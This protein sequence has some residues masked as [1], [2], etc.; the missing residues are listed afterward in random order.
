MKEPRVLHVNDC[1]FTTTVL[2]REARR[3]RLPWTYQPL[4]TADPTWHGLTGKLRYAARAAPWVVSLGA[5]AARTD[6]LHIHFATVVQH[7]G[8]VPRPYVL[9]LHGTDIRTYQ[10]DPRYAALVARAVERAAAVLYST[11]DLRV[12]AHRLRPDATHFPVPVNVVALPFWRPPAEPTVFFASRWEP[13]KGLPVQLAIARELT[14]RH[15]DDIRLVGVDWGV[16]SGAARELGVELRPRASHHEFLEHLAQTH[17]V[18]GQPTG[19]LSASELEA[20]GI[21]VPV[22]APLR[23]QWYLAAGE[24]DDSAELAPSP[25]VLGGIAIGR[26]YPL[27]EQDPRWSTGSGGSLGVATAIDSGPSTEPAAATEPRRS[28]VST[29]AAEWTGAIE[30]DAVADLARALADQVSEALADPGLAARR[31]NGREWMESAHGSGGAVERL[32]E[33][34]RDL[35]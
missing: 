22:V 28:A 27:P 12:H 5:R 2:L 25:P 11:P 31:A 33:L 21:G 23:P 13:V 34:Y 4:T 17:V 3:R 15:C 6:L 7:T 9:H 18:V 26:A 10:Y 8:W 14:R 19:M 24:P 30:T 35:T 32:R 20:I 29:Q 16:G 1:A